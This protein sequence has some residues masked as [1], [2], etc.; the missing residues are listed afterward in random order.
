M[1]SIGTYR[2][3]IPNLLIFHFLFL[4]VSSHKIE[5][6]YNRWIRKKRVIQFSLSLAL[7]LKIKKINFVLQF[8]LTYLLLT[9]EWY[10]YPCS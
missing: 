4:I 6:I 2:T 7:I 5:F 3:R 9:V 8:P 1:N 10:S